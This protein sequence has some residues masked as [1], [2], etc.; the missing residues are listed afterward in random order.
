MGNAS[1]LEPAALYHACD[2]AQ[3][4]FTTTADLTDL[5]QAIGQ[6]RARSAV[7]FGLG[8]Q[9]YGY[10]LFVMGSSGTGKH[11]LVRQCLERETG[12]ERKLFDWVY[13]NNFQHPHK[14]LA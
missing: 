6:A 9:R 13:V 10:N 3:F 12:R 2:P 1:R 11:E 4:R 7:T 8:I 5:E 14:P